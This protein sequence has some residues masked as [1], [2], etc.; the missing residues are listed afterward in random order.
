MPDEPPTQGELNAAAL[1][2]NSTVGP[3]SSPDGLKAPQAHSGWRHLTQTLGYTLPA[4]LR[5]TNANRRRFGNV[6]R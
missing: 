1:A 3:H 4:A 5:R 2:A 6:L